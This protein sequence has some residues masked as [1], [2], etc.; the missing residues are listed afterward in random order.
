MLQLLEKGGPI[1]WP[2][3]IVSVITLAVILERAAF[4]ARRARSR[5]REGVRK[6]LELAARDDVEHAV[7][8]GAGSRDPVAVILAEGLRRADDCYEEAISCAAEAELDRYER[9][10][11][12]LD[13]VVTL[14]PL[15]GLLGTVTGMIRSFGLLGASELD[16]PVAITGGIA[17]ALIATAFGL[18]LAILALIPL[19]VLSTCKQRFA[20][21]VE[22]AASRLEVIL[23]TRGTKSKQ[24]RAA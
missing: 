13:T 23:K 22:D 9:G 12:L 6:L 21:E 10:L 8:A 17:E 16:A 3:L 19:N 4:L 14:A 24:M 20:R 7:R 5:N 1:M 2:L 11:P 18:T 15:M